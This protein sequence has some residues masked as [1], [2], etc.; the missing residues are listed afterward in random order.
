MEG[1]CASMWCDVC[2]GV[3]RRECV[4]GGKE[5]VWIYM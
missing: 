3:Q 5:C 2:R 1:I 4:G